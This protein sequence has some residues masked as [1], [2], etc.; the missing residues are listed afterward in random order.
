MELILPFK[1]LLF[2]LSVLKNLYGPRVLLSVHQD[3][4]GTWHRSG[5]NG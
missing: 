2:P 3:A 4:V 5:C 1:G